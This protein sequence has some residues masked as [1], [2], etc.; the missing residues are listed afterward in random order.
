MKTLDAIIGW[1]GAFAVVIVTYTIVAM[2]L[3]E[4]T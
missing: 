3:A 1:L 4:I 2:V